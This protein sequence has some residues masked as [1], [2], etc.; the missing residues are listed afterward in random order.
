[1]AT[2]GHARYTYAQYVAVE[3]QS[4][5]KHEFLDGAIYAMAGGT[6]RARRLPR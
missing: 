6:Q 3:Q 4:D 2:A 1:M 5:I